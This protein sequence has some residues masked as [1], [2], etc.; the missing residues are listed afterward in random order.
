MG[1]NGL[2]ASDV[3]LLNNDGMGG[4][5]WG[6]MIWL[7]AILAMM[8]GGFNFGGSTPVKYIYN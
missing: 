6:G 7:F 8:G 3:A 2:S 5:G 1:E 4:N